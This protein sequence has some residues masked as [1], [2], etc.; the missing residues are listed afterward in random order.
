VKLGCIA[1]DLTGAT[2]L[3]VNLQRAGWRVVQLNG[4]PDRALDLR[5]LVQG[6]VAGAVQVDVADAAPAIDAVVVALKS[7]TAPVAQAVAQSLASA[8]WLRAHGAAR[9]F[10]KIC[11]TFDSTP[12][13]NI[14]PVADA[15]LAATGS[16]LNVVTPAYPRNG[17]TVYRGHLFVGDA[18]LADTG[19]RTHPLTPMT[20]SNLVRVLAAQTPHPVALLPQSVVA[21]GEEAVRAEL[22]RLAAA[23]ARHVIADATDDAHLATLGQVLLQQA[24]AATPWLA[25]GGA[26][27]AAGMAQAAPTL[28]G[29][30]S[31]VP[32]FVLPAG[33]TAILAGSCST[34]TQ[35]QVAAARAQMPSLQ[36]DPL[37]LARE[38]GGVDDAV[39]WL[40]DR[41]AHG[42]A[43]VYATATAEAR[44]ANEQQLGGA[45]AALLIENAF[46]SLAR[47][48]RAAGAARI[49]V[50]GGE[51]SGAVIEAL[52]VRALQI[53][54]EIDPG[55]P[56][57]L[58]PA[59]AHG[60]PLALALKSGNFGAE[61]F[62]LKVLRA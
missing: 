4:V 39:R 46:K 11:S 48:A 8:A 51:T 59:D 49:V 62:F 40:R 16:R 1:D 58:A 30:A 31:A 43:L 24:A 5:Q 38:P 61:D 41:L 42:A 57:T 13:G 21:Q 3:A 45:Q 27:L 18:L 54:P 19:M 23:G 37:Q 20:D 7:R 35:A 34:A 22:Q 53:G 17:R 60:P 25:T 36:L 2:D 9:L 12:A 55:V 15:L 29:G 33:P 28:P 52:A 47:A 56:W 14:G 6:P 26:G 50:A 44:A 32:A 10:F